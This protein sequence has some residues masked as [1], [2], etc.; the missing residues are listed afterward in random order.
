M[1]WSDLWGFSCDIQDTSRD[2]LGLFTGQTVYWLAD[3]RHWVWSCLWWSEFSYIIACSANHGH[4]WYSNLLIP[5]ILQFPTIMAAINRHLLTVSIC[6]QHERRLQACV[7][8]LMESRIPALMDVCFPHWNRFTET[9]RK[10][11]SQSRLCVWLHG[12]LVG[13]DAKT[14]M[15][16]RA[17]RWA[18]VTALH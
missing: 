8:G 16:K 10:S 11:V 3:N 17:R 12:T 13:S 7:D 18:T 4:V 2:P 1:H 14:V 6:H 5:S 9:R 15:L